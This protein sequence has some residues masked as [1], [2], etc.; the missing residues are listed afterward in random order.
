MKTYL[1]SFFAVFLFI[2]CSKNDNPT[3]QTEADILA[4]LEENNI[5]A[6]K[7]S[8]GLYYVIQKQGTGI[9][10]ARNSDVTVAYRGTFLDGTIFDQNTNGASF[11]LRGVIAGWT[12]GIPLFR[13]GGEGT[14]IV[15]YQLGYG[16]QGRR[17]IPGGSVL[18]FDIKLI[19]VN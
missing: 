4:Y 10:P 5:S 16:L 18:V 9:F 12:E 11:N 19:S 3:P 7:T 1:Y 8:S 17:P 2:A 15:P 13:E 6:Q 14:L